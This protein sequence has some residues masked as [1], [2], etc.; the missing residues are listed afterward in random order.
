MAAVDD[1]KLEVLFEQYLAL[2][3]D[4]RVGN[5]L[6]RQFRDAGLL[7]IGYY[8]Q[9]FLDN[10]PQS[11]RVFRSE[12]QDNRCFIGV[13]PPEGAALGDLWFDVVEL[14]I[15]MLVS[16]AD[17]LSLERSQ[18]LAI[19][20]TYVWQFRTF[21]S[22]VY[23]RLRNQYFMNAPDVMQSNRFETMQSMAFVT[24]LYQE[25]AVAYAHWFRKHLCGR[26]DLKG[27]KKFL[28]SQRFVT[29]LPKGMRLWDE[30]EYPESEFERIAVSLDTID[31]YPDE[32][33]ERM[34]V[35]E[36]DHRP[37]IGCSTRVPANKGLLD[38]KVPKI[39]YEFVEL[40]NL[41][42]RPK[43]TGRLA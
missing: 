9:T 24:N 27:A 6:C 29:L 41:A 2:D 42:P 12:E 35:D 3:L 15:M 22:M 32:D 20:P 13:Y 1:K 43:V 26:Y 40:L 36:W 11:V 5:Q 21:L 25:E 31:T 4:T 18:W 30:A 23:W 33:P 28:T 38:S 39:A 8:L 34:L 19:Q 14:T 7:D 10:G 37:D 17:S 16:P